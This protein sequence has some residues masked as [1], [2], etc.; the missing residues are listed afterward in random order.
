MMRCFF[1][2]ISLISLG[3]SGC[4]KEEYSSFE[5]LIGK[6]PKIAVIDASFDKRI[7]STAKDEYGRISIPKYSFLRSQDVL[8]DQEDLKFLEESGQKIFENLNHVKLVK[9][10][11]G[12]DVVT[13]SVY[14]GFLDKVVSPK[15]Q[16][17]FVQIPPY[18]SIYFQK[19]D[20]IKLCKELNVEAVL[21][22]KFAYAFFV[23]ENLIKGFLKTLVSID[24]MKKVFNNLSGQSDGEG[25]FDTIGLVADIV[26]YNKKGKEIYSGQLRILVPENRNKE[27]KILGLSFHLYP[28]YKA[29]FERCLELQVWKRYFGSQE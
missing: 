23:H 1:I 25:I 7:Y 26:V 29:S 19:E 27:L 11:N 28:E 3:L 13:A 18:Q 8:P 14:Q 5:E 24:R 6:Y 10:I 4:L 15:E 12:S 16:D 22:V 17:L 2:F 21:K 9:F 20:L